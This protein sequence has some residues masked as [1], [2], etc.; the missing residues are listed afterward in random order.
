MRKSSAT[1]R[2]A[3][4][5]LP[6]VVAFDLTIATQVFG[7]EGH[8]RY[9]TTVCALDSGPVSTTTAGL[10]LTVAATLDALDDADTVIVPG[11]RRGPAPKRALE[12]LR[13]A[14]GRGTR[15]ASICTGAF[16]LAQAG[17]LDGRRATTHWAHADALADEHPRVLVDPN[18]LY[19]D[20][21]EVLT[22]AGLAAGLDLCL[23]LVGRDHGQDVAIHR[24]RHLVTPLHRAGGQAQFI[25][26]GGE[27]EDDELVAVTAWAISN[28]HRRIT[29][30]D[31]ARQGVMSSRTLHRSFQNRFRMSPRA[32]LIQQRLR[33][34]CTL[35]ENGDI[36]VDE[37]ARRTG[38]GTATNLRAHFQ[39]AFA[40]TP[41]AYR[42]AFTP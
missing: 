26:V 18:A 36:T 39:R 30:A 7:H 17:L 8:G 15:I 19:I 4:L 24:A 20:E 9:A 34:A 29:V 42:R 41:T 11:F 27:G 21:G 13:L 35:L 28:L 32:W 10:G 14:H 25:P 5:A 2:V 23:Y 40:T 12:A 38:L 6:R 3:V 33:A 22:S 1:H 31:L 37:V 16:A